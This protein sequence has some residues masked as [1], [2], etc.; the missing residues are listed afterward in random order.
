MKSAFA[1]LR[2]IFRT[3]HPATAAAVSRRPRSSSL[4]RLYF[5]SGLASGIA[6]HHACAVTPS[7]LLTDASTEFTVAT[8]N[9]EN[10]LIR[11]I[12]SRAEKSDA[13]RSQVTSIVLQLHPDVL[14]L[15]EIGSSDALEDLRVRLH[16]RGLDLPYAEFAP[17]HDPAIAVAVLS[18]FPILRAHRHTNLSFVL[19]GRRFRTSRAFSE[20]ELGI[21]P[22]YRL[23]LVNA[24]LKSRRTVPEA[25]EAEIRAQEAICL[26][27]LIDRI[28]ARNRRAN[29]ILCGDLNDSPDS[30]ALRIVRGSGTGGLLDTRPSERNGDR[31]PSADSRYPARRIHWTHYFSRDDL[32]SRIDY[33]LLSRPAAR[34]WLPDGSYVFSGPDWGLAS[35]HRPV[36][37]RLMAVDR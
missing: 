7:Q 11:P 24:H 3:L 4:T 13:A 14:A 35:D 21:A 26:R 15:Q 12:Q 33:I 25:D 8:Y 5:L 19:D 1:A 23:I 28:Q 34:E 27:L 31:A 18:R 17:G 9:V 2:S 30:P 10:Y 37:V 20:V 16:S 32:Y 29:V 36:L 6:L 22:A